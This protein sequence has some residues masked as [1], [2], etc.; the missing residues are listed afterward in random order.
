MINI[1]L[2]EKKQAEKV[3]LSGELGKKPV[4]ALNLI[5]RY[6]QQIKCMKPSDLTEALNTYMALNV[7][8]YNPDIWECRIELIVKNA[9]KYPLREIEYIGITQ[10]ELDTLLSVPDEKYRRLAFVILCCAKFHNTVSKNNNG[11]ANTE[12]M[13]IFSS[14]RVNTRYKDDKFKIIYKLRQITCSDGS[15][16]FSV[17]QK[18][19]NTN[20]QAHYIDMDGCPVLKISDFRELGYEYVNYCK[21][22]LFTRCNRC[23]ILVKKSRRCPKYCLNCAKIINREKTKERMSQL[24]DCCV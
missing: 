16:M 9:K 23:E 2:N 3:Y 4:A 12:I 21:P 15:P 14:A 7:P 20:I 1:I 22:K 17:A 6:L 10:E 19:T 13:D 5:G 11:W 24:R 18:N 8:G